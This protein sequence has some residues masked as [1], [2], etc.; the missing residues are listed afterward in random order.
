MNQPFL[1]PGQQEK[2]AIPERKETNQVNSIIVPDFCMAAISK[3]CIQKRAP[4]AECSRVYELRKNGVQGTCGSWELQTEF[5]K[6]GS[7]KEN[8]HQKSSYGSP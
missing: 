2:I 6:G 5:Q 3:L 1:D 8:E 7:Y 4:L